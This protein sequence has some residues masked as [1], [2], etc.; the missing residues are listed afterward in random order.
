[1]MRDFSRRIFSLRLVR[2]LA[3]GGTAFI[4]DYA[5]LLFL[6]EGFGIYYL[7]SATLGF[8]LGGLVCY[9]LSLKWVFE[10]RR[11]DRR[12]REISLF[13]IIGIIGLGLN[14][15]LLWLFT[16]G[17]QIPYQYGKL[18]AAGIILLFNYYSR[19]YLVFTAR[20]G[21]G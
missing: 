20:A 17:A 6:T 8:I 16:D 11:F 21:R 9:M 3:A 18:L 2:Y 13:M 19:L 7:W 10:E 4:V 5:T 12:S 14:N 15:L 1:M